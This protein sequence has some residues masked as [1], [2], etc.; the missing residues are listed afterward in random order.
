M[1][2]SFSSGGRRSTRREPPNMGKQLANFIICDCESSAPFFCNLQSRVRTHAVL[3]IDIYE[4][5][6]NPTTKLIEPPGLLKMKETML[7]HKNGVQSLL[8]FFLL[9]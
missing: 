4:L 8:C 6:G 2:T 1:A 5:L 3:V 9:N 7:L